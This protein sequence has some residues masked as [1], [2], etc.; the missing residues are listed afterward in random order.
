MGQ[1]KEVHVFR[2][3]LGGYY[4]CPLQPPGG[5][6]PTTPHSREADA[7]GGTTPLTLD[8]YTA[9]L[10]LKK[11]EYVKRLA[12]GCPPTTPHYRADA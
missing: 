5:T 3:R 9:Q 6:P 4:A 7:L 8:M 1:E 11:D 10:H 12:R 2:Y